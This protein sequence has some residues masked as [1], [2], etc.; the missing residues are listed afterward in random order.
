MCHRESDVFSVIATPQQSAARSHDLLHF[1]KP[2]GLALLL[3]TLL[4][5]CSSAPEMTRAGFLSDYSRL[6]S[7]NDS[8][9][10]YIAPELREYKSF[11]VDPVQMSTQKGDLSAEDRAEITL[12]FRDTLT[13][14]LM[15]RGYVITET[16]GVG[17]ARVR[18]AITGVQDST[19]WLKLHPGSNLS[20]AGRGGAAM[21]GEIID[22]VT[23]EQL[24]GVVQSSSGS[25][26]TVGNFSTVADIKNV[27]DEWAKTAGDRLDE[28]RELGR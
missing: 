2:L 22:S 9:M 15:N 4:G 27:I 8:R 6:T 3:S 18:I 19:W 5:G 11:I 21:E 12:Y 25:Q 16:P 10:R 24:A 17:V 26:F 14:I 13:G 28:L 1:C 7:V 20:G 23:G